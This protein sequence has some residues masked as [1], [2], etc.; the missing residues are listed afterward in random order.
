MARKRA[1]LVTSVCPD[2][3]TLAAFVEGTL[4]A[5][6]VSGLERHLDA[7]NNCIA[8]VAA[9]GGDFSHGVRPTFG[10][11]GMLARRFE[12]TEAMHVLPVRPGQIF[13]DRYR[14]GRYLAQGGHGAVFVAEHLMTEAPVALKVLWHDSRSTQSTAGA[15]A[16]EA[17][18]ANRVMSDYIVR[19]LDAGV[20]RSSATPYLAMELLEGH[21]LSD[22]VARNGPL[23][24][25]D[26]TL[27]LSHVAQG[28]DSAHSLTSAAGL[29]TPVV[30]RDL[31]PENLFL[32]ARTDGR[33]IVKILDF[34]LAKLAKE[35]GTITGT[36][37]GTP[38]YMASEQITCGP[39]GPCTDV[40][41]FGLVAFYLLSGR[42]YWLNAQ[43]SNFRPFS[44]LAEVLHDPLVPPSTRASQLEI[45]PG[46]GPS[47]RSMVSGLR[48]S[49][50]AG[51][52]PIRR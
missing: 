27:Y 38:C 35:N 41:A 51:A 24:V 42:S 33:P 49:R 30:H 8:V 11:T 28:L 7:C 9:L 22:L 18:L 52:L 36:V 19:V 5:T 25:R 26:V 6:A 29:S 14:V 39:I 13:A 12:Q 4:E 17:K 48:K 32:T 15:I 45:P 31:K 40:W 3:H 2:E 1:R 46:G 10:G 37:C 43:P 50:S 34:G 44:V 16:K 20:E 47:V 21:C 23:D